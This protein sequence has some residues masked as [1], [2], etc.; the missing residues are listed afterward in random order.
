MKNESATES[1][2]RFFRKKLEKIPFNG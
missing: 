2:T 1:A